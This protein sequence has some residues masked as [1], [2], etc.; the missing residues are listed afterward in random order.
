MGQALLAGLAVADP[1]QSLLTPDVGD[2]QRHNVR[3]PEA[4]AVGGQGR[5]TAT[6]VCDPLDRVL[7]V[8]L[9][10]GTGERVGN[11]ASSRSAT[12]GRGNALSD[13]RDCPARPRFT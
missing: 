11:N 3:D 1:E 9:R 2:L 4:G 8:V 13:S 6:Q 7:D 10:N 5:R 12:L